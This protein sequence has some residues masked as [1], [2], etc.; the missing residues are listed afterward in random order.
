MAKPTGGEKIIA[1]NPARSDYFVSEI[2]ECGIA[3]QGTEV[4]SLRI[5]APSL[6]DA[7]VE[8]VQTHGGKKLEAWLVN[9]HIPV[10][11][12]GNIWNH[13][14]SRRR[15]LLLHRHQI[16]QIFGMTIQKG[17]TAIPTRMYFKNGRVKV[18][19]GMGKGKKKGDKRDD[20]KKRS[21]DREIQQAMKRSR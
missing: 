17:M 16:E 18:E 4:K 14:P 12:H 21:A 1:Q 7:F 19:V 3:L 20:Q 11:T 8:V 10:Y 5:Q 15:K 9:C 6:R 2:V 13:E